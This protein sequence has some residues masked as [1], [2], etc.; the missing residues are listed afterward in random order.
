[1]GCNTANFLISRRRQEV[2]ASPFI[3][4]IPLEEAA[5]TRAL[6]RTR[7]FLSGRAELL[8][9]MFRQYP[10]LSAWLVAYS[11]SERYGEDD[12]AIYP[13]ISNTFGVP[14][15]TLAQRNIIFNEFGENC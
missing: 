4:L 7:K 13:H 5:R 6:E 14:L 8:P 12:H 2:G 15:D 1:M 3:G 9:A 10:S 11:L